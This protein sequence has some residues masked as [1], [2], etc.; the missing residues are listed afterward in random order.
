METPKFPV[1]T[2]AVAV[3]LLALI[4]LVLD[5][6][7]LVWHIKNRNLG[8]ASLVSWLVLCN[9][10]NMVNALIWPTNDIAHWWHGQVFCDIQVKLMV[11]VYAG[12]AGSLACIMGNLA[13]VL[14]TRKTVL[15]PSPAQRLRR[16]VAD[17]LLCFGVPICLILVHYIVQPCRYYILAIAGCWPSYDNSWPKLALIFIWPPVLC[18]IA[19]YYC[20]MSHSL[21]GVAP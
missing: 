11:A 10:F 12:V 4:T 15:V 7:P 8:A 2:T 14:D 17:S 9:L 21:I 19:F 6:P 18:L 16:M 1:T 20:G 3:P 5:V 13:A